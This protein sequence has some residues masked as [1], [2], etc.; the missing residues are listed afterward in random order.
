MHGLA[1]AVVDDG[2]VYNLTLSLKHA[3]VHRLIDQ[4]EETPRFLNSQILML[5]MFQRLVWM[6]FA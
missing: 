1:D 2:A 5:F 6:S 3:A 4:Q